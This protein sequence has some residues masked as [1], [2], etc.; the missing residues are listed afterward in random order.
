[1]NELIAALWQ[2]HLDGRPIAIVGTAHG[3]FDILR[4]LNTVEYP[5]MTASEI[6]EDGNWN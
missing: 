6:M 5:S 1:M 2:A 4:L 3:A